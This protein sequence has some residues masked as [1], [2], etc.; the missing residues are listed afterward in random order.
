AQS[1]AALFLIDQ[2]A[3]HERV[4]FEKLMKGFKSGSFEV[5]TF[6]I[7]LTKDFEPTKMDSLLNIAPELKKMGVEIEQSG[8]QTLSVIS[9]PHFVKEKALFEMLHKISQDMD[10]N[11]GSFALD[12]VVGDIFATMA[13][14]SSIRA[15]QSLSAEE[16]RE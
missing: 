1:R 15:G 6:L 2:H 14:H 10:E 7:P 3:S 5:Q 16:M 4:N 11:G 13:C 8:P 9:A 12:K